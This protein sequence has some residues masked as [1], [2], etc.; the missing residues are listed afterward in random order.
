MAVPTVSFSSF[1]FSSVSPRLAALSGLIIVF[2]GT[3]AGLTAQPVPLDSTVVT[4]T[5]NTIDTTIGNGVPTPIALPAEGGLEQPVRYTA[6]DSLRIVFADPDSTAEGEEPNDRAY[7]YGNVTANYGEATLSAGIIELL[8]RR[9]ELRA[10]PME[11]DSGQTEIPRFSEGSEAFTGREFVY[12]MRTRRGRVVGARTQVEDG[13]LLGGIIKQRDAHIIYAQDAAYTTCE[14]DH[15]HYSLEAGR[16][17]IVDGEWIYTGPV[18]LSILGIPMPVWLPFGFFPAAEGRRSGPL[19]ISYGED[20]SAFGFYLENVG[21]YWA[22]SD[23]FDALVQGKIGTLGSYQIDTRFNYVRR[24]GFD[25]TL[26][27]SYARL[28]RGES[29]D[30]DFAIAQNARV[31]WRH[32]QTFTP[33]TSLNASVDLT[34]NSQRFISNAFD[35]RV[36][37]TSTSSISFRHNWPRGGRSLSVDTRAT[38]QLSTGG[39]NLTLPSL[40]FSQQRRFPFRRQRLAGRNEA[41]FEKIGISYTGSLTNTFDFTPL[42][43]SMLVGTSFQDVSWVNAL[44]SQSDYEGATG[45][46]V[47]R[48]SPQATHTIPVSASFSLQAPFRVNWSPSVRYTE[49]WHARSDF[50]S[51][52]STG[53]IVTRQESGFTAIRRVNL[54]VSANTEFYGLF[55]FRLGPLDGIRHTVQPQVSF[56][57]EPDYSASPFN[58]YRTVTDTL[59]Q[60]IEYPIVGGIPN[61]RTQ[62][63]GFSLRNVFQTRIVRTDSTGEE[64]RNTIQ[65]FTLGAR[66]AYDFAADQRPF[67]DVI[68]DLTSQLNR[69]RMRADATFSPY[70][71]DSLGLITDNAYVNETG[72]PLRLTRFNLSAGASFRSSSAGGRPSA[73]P[74]GYD[75]PFGYDPSLPGAA[76][77]QNGVV[78]FAIPWSLSLDF[79]YGITPGFGSQDSQRSAILSVSSFDFSLTPRWKIAGRTGYDF[80]RE[81]LSTTSLSVVRDLHCWEMRFNW[82]PFGAF[83]SFNFSI[84]VKSGH[85]RDFLRLD[86]PQSDV[87]NRFGTLF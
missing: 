3:T 7:L 65:L 22:V 43:D 35:D 21:W 70:A 64:T 28:R 42:A 46:S 12:N 56:S 31:R 25:G 13:F 49:N 16:M 73:L 57:Y 87:Q 6:R 38:Q 51:L 81:E 59:G 84:Y 54:G 69:Y 18:R 45:R 40:S 50:R 82:I 62:R 24:Y 86:V 75:A 36:S 71:L 9:Q 20:R 85:L 68:L 48:F 66:S 44:F 8:F 1:D 63:L 79:T 60:N 17:K 80:E 11:S 2:S 10:T 67:A 29:Q 77:T 32:A 34:S 19:A 23:H 72:R 58:Y 47:E 33:N 53:T 14:L 37:Q 4:D 30:P 26:D 76:I 61:R 27:L 74:P 41:W 78:D 55:P 39:A 5:L 15:P 83:S 52:D